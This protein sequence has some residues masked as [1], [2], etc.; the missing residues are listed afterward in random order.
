MKKVLFFLVL[1]LALSSCA[2]NGCIGKGYGSATQKPDT[3]KRVM[4]YRPIKKDKSSPSIVEAKTLKSNGRYSN[5]GCK[6]PKPQESY[7][8]L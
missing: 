1:V 8:R 6:P 2:T 4:V 3:Q 5:K 7:A